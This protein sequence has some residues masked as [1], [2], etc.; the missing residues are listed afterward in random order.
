MLCSALIFFEGDMQKLVGLSSF[1]FLS[2]CAASEDCASTEAKDKVVESLKAQTAFDNAPD[3]F[4]VQ[5]IRTEKVDKAL[6][7]S[8]CAANVELSRFG[9]RGVT[10]TKP[11]TWK[12]PITYTVVESSAG[13]LHVKVKTAQ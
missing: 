1:L 9:A 7:T 8:F 4:E 13:T 11:I 2:A 5:D 3:K 6:K 10:F 12:V